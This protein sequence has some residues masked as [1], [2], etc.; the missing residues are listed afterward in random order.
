[1]VTRALAEKSGLRVFDYS[2]HHPI[3]DLA[4]LPDDVFDRVSPLPGIVFDSAAQAEWAERE[5]A[6]FIA[7]FGDGPDRWTRDNPFYETGDAEIAYAFV[8]HIRPRRIIE[9]GSGYSTLVVAHAVEH[10]RA[11]G[12]E[13]SY[14]AFNPWWPASFA[15]E[16]KPPP[17]LDSHERIPAEEVPLTEFDELESGDIL[18]VDTSHTVKLAGDVNRIVLEVLPRLKPGVWVHFHDIWL[19]FEYHENLVR[20]MKLYWNEQYLLQAFLSMNPAYEVVFGTRAVAGQ[21]P[22]R[23]DALVPGFAGRE[24]YPSSFWLRRVA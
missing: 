11:A 21:Q 4:V 9:L 17:G 20:L 6:G 18:F 24:K 13:V 10:N 1:V 7:E 22:D 19:P 8:R 3:P 2:F 5:L 23:F 15:E 14:R 16:G 12:D